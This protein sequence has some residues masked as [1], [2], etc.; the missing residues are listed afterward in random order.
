MDRTAIK[1]TQMRIESARTHT[2]H[3]INTKKHNKYRKIEI[4][5]FPIGPSSQN[6]KEANIKSLR[7]SKQIKKNSN[8]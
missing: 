8:I 1:H 7:N 4:R 6:V 3:N 5:A 2:L